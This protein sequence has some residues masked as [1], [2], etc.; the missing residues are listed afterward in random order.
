MTRIKPP[1]RRGSWTQ[2]ARIGGQSFYLG[3]GERADG[4]L[5]EIFLTCQKEGTFS[6]GILDSLARM[7]SAALQSGMPV[8]EVVK[9]LIGIRFPPDGEVQGSLKVDR[10]VS[11][12]D[13]MAKEMEAYYSQKEDE[14]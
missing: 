3:F 7:V 2:K 14:Q 5:C 6:R 4:T 11:V 1:D 13:W 12:V 8:D 9:V 10:C